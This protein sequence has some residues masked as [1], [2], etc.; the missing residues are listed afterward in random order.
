METANLFLLP[1]LFLFA[2]HHH[3][4]RRRH[5]KT[6]TKKLPPGPLA[7]PV[8]GHLLF[9]A[10]KPLHQSLARLATR[11]GPVFSLRLGSRHAVVVSSAACARE[12]LTEHD[13]TFAGR[14]RFPTLALMTYGGTTVVNYNYGPYWR[15]LRR[16][17]TVHLLSASRVT[18]FMLPAIT[19]EVRAMARRMHRTAAAAAASGRSGARVHLRRRLLELIL[20]AMMET[21]AQTKTSRAAED[22]DTDMSPETQE[23]KE[24]MDVLLP[25]VGAANTWDFLPILQ[26]LDVFGVKKKIAS[27]VGTRDAFFQRLI[28]TAR[29]DVLS[30]QY[31]IPP[32]HAVR[33][34][35]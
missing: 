32:K 7:V 21:V 35:F 6:S 28:D 24:S 2:T 17:A 18:S 15:H 27:V 22:A 26:R 29:A 14:P 13:V 23:F 5:G 3:L 9:L 31:A 1:F 16:V 8:F 12:C 33:M 10:G 25:L 19:A 11:Y 34:S 30:P 4:T 20:S